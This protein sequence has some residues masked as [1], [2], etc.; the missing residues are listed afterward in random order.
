[1][2][3]FWDRDKGILLIKMGSFF[4]EN[5]VF[6]LDYINC[7]GVLFKFYLNLIFIWYLIVNLFYMNIVF[8]LKM[9]ILYSYLFYNDKYFIYLIRY[10]KIKSGF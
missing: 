5:L 1:M 7:I 8:F 9:I 2:I 3:D 6:W 10:I 4:I